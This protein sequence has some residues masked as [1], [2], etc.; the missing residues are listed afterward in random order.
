[1]FWTKNA[2]VVAVGI[3]DLHGWLSILVLV[4]YNAAYLPLLM[5]LPTPDHLQRLLLIF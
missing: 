4:G 1:M 3:V 5:A 2:N